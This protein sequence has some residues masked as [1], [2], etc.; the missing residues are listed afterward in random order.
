MA[1][2]DRL[3]IDASQVRRLIARQCPQWADLP[4]SAVRWNGWDN[5]TFRLGDSMKVRLPTAGAY[6]PQVEKE[7]HWLPKLAPHLPIAIPVPLAIGEPDAD[8]PWRWSVYEWIDGETASEEKIADLPQ[9]ARD[10]GAF[11]RALQWI[12]TADGPPAGVR[13][14]FRGGALSHYDAETRDAL[15]LLRP[16]I[17]VTA[18][19]DLWGAAMAA[20]WHAPPVWVH[21]DISVGNLLVRDG[22]LHAIIDFGSCAIG[23]PACDLV[24]TWTFLKGESRDAF[25]NAVS[26]DRS[27][28]A[29]ARGWALWKALITHVNQGRQHPAEMPARQIIDT[30]LADH[31]I[32]G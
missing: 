18:A 6:V 30:V 11:L 13:N 28:W 23:D 26:A 9:F 8:Y 2:D 20:E 5:A 27:M 21:G 10:V 14:F 19:A 31:R 22:R 7:H 1:E 24:L 17:D 4:V 12:D 3:S 25:R 15:D 29:R 32:N 16:E